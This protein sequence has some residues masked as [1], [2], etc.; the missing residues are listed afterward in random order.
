MRRTIN[1]LTRPA[2]VSP[3]KRV[4]WRLRKKWFNRYQKPAWLGECVV[5]VSK[6]GKTQIPLRIGDVRMLKAGGRSFTLS[7]ASTPTTS[8]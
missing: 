2:R 3:K 8:K 6:D 4:S 1:P 5:A 7:F